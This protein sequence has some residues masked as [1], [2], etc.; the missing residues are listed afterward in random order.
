MLLI[1]K[2]NA[3]NLV[4]VHETHHDGGHKSHDYA[5][6]GVAG[7]A[8]GL[9]IAG[10][11]GWLLNAIGSG[12]FLNFGCNNRCTN[13]GQTPNETYLERKECEDY[14]A[15]TNAMWKQAYEAQAARFNDRDVLNKEL[16]GVYNGMRNGFD[17]L[18]SKHNEDSFALYKYSRD[19]NDAVMAQIGE[20]K[21]ELAVLKATRPYQD[22]LIQCAI[23][24]VAQNADF[25]LWRRTCRMISGQVILPSTP[26]VSGYGSYTDC[27]CNQTTTTSGQ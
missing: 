21:A 20:M 25:N 2:E 8:L 26:A 19:S 6:K 24:N 11:A 10:T 12:N 27:G 15:L 17:A 14:I 16:F 1:E 5:S 23:D 7:T 22:K 13:G 18:T 4:E 3:K 9:G